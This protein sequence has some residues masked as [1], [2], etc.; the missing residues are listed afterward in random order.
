VDGSFRDEASTRAY[1]PSAVIAKSMAIA[2]VAATRN[3]RHLREQRRIFSRITP[4]SFLVQPFQSVSFV[5]V[6][7]DGKVL[8]ARFNHDA[9]KCGPLKC[10]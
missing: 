2:M 1:A 9:I 5:A 7:C 4:R 3:S 6:I 10:F 8:I